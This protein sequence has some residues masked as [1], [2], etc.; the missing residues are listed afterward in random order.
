MLSRFFP[1]VFVDSLG[2]FGPIHSNV[3]LID[4]SGCIT[5][6]Q[7]RFKGFPAKLVVLPVVTIEETKKN[8]YNNVLCLLKK[9]GK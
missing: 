2:S 4:T 8:F 7:V 3:G 5:A 9:K 6:V 1:L